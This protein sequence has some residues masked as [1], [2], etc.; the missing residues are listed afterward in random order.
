M[1]AATTKAKQSKTNSST[2]NVWFLSTTFICGTF[3]NIDQTIYHRPTINHRFKLSIYLVVFFLINKCLRKSMKSMTLFKT[4]E[5]T[6][7]HMQKCIVY[8]DSRAGRPW[9]SSVWETLFFP[10]K[11]HST[12]MTS[13]LKTAMAVTHTANKQWPPHP[14]SI[15]PALAL[16]HCLCSSISE[17]RNIP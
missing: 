14:R 1:K 15:L 3:W 5:H 8:I 7:V 6:W 17:Q 4:N 13:G 10:T 9:T 16:Q 11:T 2:A 12:V